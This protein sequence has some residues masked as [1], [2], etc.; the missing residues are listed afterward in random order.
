MAISHLVWSKEMADWGWPDQQ[1][2]TAAKL[3]RLLSLALWMV[4]PL[5]GQIVGFTLGVYH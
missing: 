1:V 4:S 2:P 5:C 3:S